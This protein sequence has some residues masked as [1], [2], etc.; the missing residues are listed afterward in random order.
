MSIYDEIYG[1]V[2]IYDEIYD[3]FLKHQIQKAVSWLPLESALEYYKTDMPPEKK[4]KIQ[5]EWA[6]LLRALAKIEGLG[7]EIRKAEGK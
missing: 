2:S 6:Y 4:A 3:A 5:Q 1:E 7:F